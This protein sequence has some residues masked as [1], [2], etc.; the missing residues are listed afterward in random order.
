MNYSLQHKV[1]RQDA[2]SKMLLCLPVTTRGRVMTSPHFVVNLHWRQSLTQAAV[3][4][5]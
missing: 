2:A 3:M 1:V 4:T 5:A